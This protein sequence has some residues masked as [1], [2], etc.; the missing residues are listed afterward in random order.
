ACRRRPLHLFRDG[1]LPCARHAPAVAHGPRRRQPDIVA[2]VV[3][4]PALVIVAPP[5]PVRQRAEIPEHVVLC[6]H[7]PPCRHP[8]INSSDHPGSTQRR[9]GIPLP[10]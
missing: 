9:Q 3:Q 2:D 8:C 4:R 7:W 5:P 10:P 6:G 1:N